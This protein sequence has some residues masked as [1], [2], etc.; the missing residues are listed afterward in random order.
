MNKFLFLLFLPVLSFAQPAGKEFKIKGELKL[1]KPVDWVYL[2]YSSG[3]QHV[4][5]SLQPQNGEFKFEGKITEPTLASLSVKFVKQP[6]EEK[7]QR[8][9]T[10]IFLEPSK[11]EIIARDSLKN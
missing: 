9:M 3:D 8:E 4:T 5:D 11:I 10:R 6:E 7:A 2:R 1:V